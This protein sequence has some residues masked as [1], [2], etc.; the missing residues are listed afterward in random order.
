MAR[1]SSL[2]CL[3]CGSPYQ[4]PHSL[5]CFPPLH[6]KALFFTEKC[7]VSS[8]SQQ[9]APINMSSFPGDFGGAQEAF[10]IQKQTFQCDFVIL[11]L[12]CRRSSHCWLKPQC[13]SQKQRFLGKGALACTHTHTT[14]SGI[15]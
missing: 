10:R 13:A 11:S 12:A 5:S 2:N 15:R 4:T 9:S 1:T 8:P 6:C 7:F 3:S 14:G